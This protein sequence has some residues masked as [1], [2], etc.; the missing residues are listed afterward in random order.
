MNK[1]CL[2]GMGLA[3]LLVFGAGTNGCAT[4]STSASAKNQPAAASP[5][6]SYAQQ[7]NPLVGPDYYQSSDNPFHAD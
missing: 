2:R 6:S 3:A 7:K 1:I 4:E 5:D